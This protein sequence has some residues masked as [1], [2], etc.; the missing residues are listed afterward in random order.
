MKSRKLFKH[1]RPAVKIYTTW[2]S[3]TLSLFFYTTTALAS[4]E[5]PRPDS[6]AIRCCRVIPGGQGM[7]SGDCVALGENFEVILAGVR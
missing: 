4:N 3:V 2:L 1:H 5:Q 6:Q 7:Y